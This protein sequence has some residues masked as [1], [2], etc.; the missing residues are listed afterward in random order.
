MVV[1]FYLYVILMT[2]YWIFQGWSWCNLYNYYGS[3]KE[4]I[5]NH[6]IMFLL[7][8]AIGVAFVILTVQWIL[9]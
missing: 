5:M 8:I 3:I 4:T 1:C 7:Q 9:L 6:K 2:C